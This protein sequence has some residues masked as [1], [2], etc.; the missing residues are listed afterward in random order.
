MFEGIS[1]RFKLDLEPHFKSV[2]RE[3]VKLWRVKRFLV[4]KG[5]ISN[6]FPAQISFFF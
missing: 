3:D 2:M 5:N 4:N 1:V 6:N